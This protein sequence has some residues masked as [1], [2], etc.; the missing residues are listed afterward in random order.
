MYQKLLDRFFKENA[1]K[2]KEIPSAAALAHFH[3]KLFLAPEDANEK[4]Q[5]FMND[6]VFKEQPKREGSVS[7]EK[8]DI[9]SAAT[10]EQIIKFM[11]GKTDPMN[12]QTLV[13]KALS[14]EDEIIPEIIRRLRT[15]LNT[16]FIEDAT[17]IL[18]ICGK[19]IAEELIGYFDDVRSPYAQSMMLLVLGFKAEETHIPWLIEQY[20]KMKR[21][22][23]SETYYDGAYYAL[24]EIEERFN[25]Y[26]KK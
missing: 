12:K 13:K 11:R 5:G 25:L 23:P 6:I 24:Y 19:D 26:Q 10:Y 20:N 9:E 15:S 4:I 18:S 16:G 21:L 1:V 7:A 8:N 22:Y 3:I 17:M 2:D 14:F